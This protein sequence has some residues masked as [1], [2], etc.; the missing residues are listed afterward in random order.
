MDN[1]ALFIDYEYC[2]GCK[3][4][5]LACRNEHDFK[6]DQWGIHV[7]EEKPWQLDDGSWEWNY[8]PLPTKLCDFCEDK[9]ARGEEPSCVMHCQAKVIEYGTYEELL[10]HLEKK[11][12]GYIIRP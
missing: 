4:C 5:E 9:V 12:M 11:P 3:S 2:S 6:P 8:I 10:P 1:R 7:L